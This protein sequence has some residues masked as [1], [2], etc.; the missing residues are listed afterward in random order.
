MTLDSKPGGSKPGGSPAPLMDRADERLK[1]QS[2]LAGSVNAFIDRVRSGDLG[3]L[4]VIVGLI[5]ISAI[6]QY[7]IRFFSLPTIWSTCCSIARPSG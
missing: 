2:G 5:V 3:S 4:P 1:D 7:I 6:F